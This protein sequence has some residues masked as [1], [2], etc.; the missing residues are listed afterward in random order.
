MASAGKKCCWPAN[1][2]KAGATL[3]RSRDDEQ[4]IILSEK[5]LGFCAYVEGETV[6]QFLVRN[7]IHGPLLSA[8]ALRLAPLA[9][10]LSAA[11][12][13]LLLSPEAIKAADELHKRRL[14]LA[15]DVDVALSLVPQSED[16]VDLAAADMLFMGPE[17]ADALR[18]KPFDAPVTRSLKPEDVK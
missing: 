8:L 10:T 15:M 2:S 3:S 14:K 1:M 18:G 6:G 7:G 16:G 4:E 5:Q 9:P 17:I 11:V 12:K 13:T